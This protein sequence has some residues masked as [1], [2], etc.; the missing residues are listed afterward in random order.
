MRCWP[1]PTTRSSSARASIPP[2]SRTSL[3]AACS[4]SASRAST[5]PATPGCRRG[6]PVETPATTIDRQCGSAQQAVNF[7]AALDRLRRPR[8]RDRRG[9]RAFGPHPDVRRPR[10]GR[11]GRASVSARAHG[12]LRPRPAGPERGDDRRPLGDP[13]VR[14][15]RARRALAAPRGAGDRGGPLRARDRAVLGQRRHL[16]RRPGHPAG[17][18]ARE[19]RR[20]SSPR[21][22]R[23]GRSPPGTRRRS[24]TARRR[25]CS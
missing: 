22:S 14:A 5:S 12:A 8:R 7:G 15:R 6:C 10:V 25:S 11:P 16:R 2:R 23:T 17:H 1:R 21:S 13:A 20:R 19:A 24:P 9:R 18:D 3:P 4:R